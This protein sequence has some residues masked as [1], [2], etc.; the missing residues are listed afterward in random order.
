MAL[1]K[2]KK[3]SSVESCDADTKLFVSNLDPTCQV[4]TDPDS[5]PTSKVVSDPHS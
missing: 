1:S 5:D 4:T 3:V 2:T